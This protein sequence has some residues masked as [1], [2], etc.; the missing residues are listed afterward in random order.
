MKPI[1]S[2][3][4]LLCLSPSIAFAY[5]DPGTG[6]L[7]L[8]S[9][10]ALFASALFF[11]KSIFYKVI[12]LTSGGGVKLKKGK[13]ENHKLVF[14]S[15]GK[16]Y[17]N[18]FKPILTYLD[19]IS[20]PYTYLTSSK[21]DFELYTKDLDSKKD[22]IQ[23]LESTTTCHTEPLGEVS[24][25]ETKK[26]ISHLRTQYDKNLES[27]NTNKHTTQNHNPNAQFEYIGS[28][29]SPKAISRLNSLKADIVMMS[30]PQL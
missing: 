25:I 16:Q 3:F 9:A 19:S 10:I 26:D 1:L 29:D 20:Y 28:S 14:Y 21:E 23:K 4:I 17:H 18:V 12:S 2:F 6:S 8:S 13:Q 11:F 15:E 5:L 30:T 27:N 24:N 7:L 22:S